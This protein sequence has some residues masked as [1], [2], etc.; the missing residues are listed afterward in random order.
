[1]CYCFD[2]RPTTATRQPLAPPGVSW[3]QRNSVAVASVAEVVAFAFAAASV[4][5][6]VVASVAVASVVAAVA[7]AAARIDAAVVAGHRPPAP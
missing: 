7:V 3:L 6:G 5:F 4:A 2:W 1:M